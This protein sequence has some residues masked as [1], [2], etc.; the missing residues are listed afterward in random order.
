MNGILGARILSTRFDDEHGALGTRK[1]AI[2]AVTLLL[3]GLMALFAAQQL[4]LN[5]SLGTVTG[6]AQGTANV[7]LDV[8][9]GEVSYAGFSADTDLHEGD[10]VLVR[11]SPDSGNSVMVVLGH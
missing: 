11:I 4:M 10:R 8:N 3:G 9:P 6:V 2:L 7:T 1:L 5:F